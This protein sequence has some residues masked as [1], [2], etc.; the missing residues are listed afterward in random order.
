[1]TEP[2]QTKYALLSRNGIC[3]EYALFWSRFY[4]DFTQINE[5]WLRLYSD[6]WATKWRVKPLPVWLSWFMGFGRR[7]PVHVAFGKTF[8]KKKTLSIMPLIKKMQSKL[9]VICFI[10]ISRSGNLYSPLYILV[11]VLIQWLQCSPD[12][13]ESCIILAR[14][15]LQHFYPLTQFCSCWIFQIL[16][17]DFSDIISSNL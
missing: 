10:Q 8:L 11:F 12:F 3:R 6:I 2:N 17:M 15:C 13:F 5:I 4:S 14:H 9:S 7:S 1:M 16:N